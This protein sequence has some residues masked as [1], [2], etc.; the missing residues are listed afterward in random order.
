MR[1]PQIFVVER[2]GRLAR[3]LRGACAERHWLLRESRRLESCLELLKKNRLA[4]LV[5]HVGRDL[6]REF[7]LVGQIAWTFPT[8]GLLIVCDAE[9]LWLHDLC[10]DLGAHFVLSSLQ[11]RTHLVPLVEALLPPTKSTVPSS[12]SEIAAL[13]PETSTIPDATSHPQ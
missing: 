10:W 8:V 12:P 7:E 5:V 3:L 2:D 1:H 11:A 9:E 6:S 13:A 4:V